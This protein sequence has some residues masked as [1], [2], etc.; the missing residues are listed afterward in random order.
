LSFFWKSGGIKDEIGY[1]F[2]VNG[3]RRFN[4]PL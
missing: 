4:G 2:L 1:T 3:E